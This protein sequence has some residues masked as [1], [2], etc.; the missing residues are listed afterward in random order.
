MNHKVLS[1]VKYSNV[2]PNLDRKDHLILYDRALLKNKSFKNWVQ[3]YPQ[4]YP[5]Q[6]GEELKSVHHFANHAEKLL[7]KLNNMSGRSSVM[8]VVGGGSVGDFGGFMASVLLRGT[9]LIHIP[10]TWLA[11]ID[12]AH[13][14]KTALNSK[15]AKNQI[16]TFYP[17]DEIIIVK[18]SLES[19]SQDQMESAMG[20]VIKMG[21]LK[22]GKL[23][24][25]VSEIEKPSH[26]ILWKLLPK[27][28]D[29]KMSFVKKDLQE[30]IGIRKHLNLGHTF[31]HLYEKVLK[32]PHGDAVLLGLD[33]S[34]RFSKHIDTK[35]NYQVLNTTPAMDWSSNRMNFSDQ[36]NRLF[37]TC[38]KKKAIQI[39]KADKKRS[40][41]GVDFVALKKPGK[42]Y[43]INTKAEMLA[44]FLF[45]LDL[46]NK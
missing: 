21:L 38:S 35:F 31:G 18:K 43:L 34:L 33:L 36:T 1:V 17:A 22:G 40:G 41:K 24:S 19:L 46:S 39:L 9:K 42:S 32:I 4:T 13:G 8:V 15:L 37:K 27:L 28:I 2:W 26:Q 45:N 20:E 16:G 23:W 30:K 12:S 44:E 10:T 29:G 25:I 3:T 7:S 11:C 6:A 5:V 14:G